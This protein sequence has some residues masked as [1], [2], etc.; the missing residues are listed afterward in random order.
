MSALP[1]TIRSAVSE[2]ETTA[3]NW[4]EDDEKAALGVWIAACFHCNSGRSHAAAVF[5]QQIGSDVNCRPDD[6][7]TRG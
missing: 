3:A 4:P 5:D 2:I 1:S 7:T 6:S